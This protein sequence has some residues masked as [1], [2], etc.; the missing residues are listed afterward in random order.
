MS[1]PE[2]SELFERLATTPSDQMA[3]AAK[4]ADHLTPEDE[5][6]YQR[7]N[8]A[9][10]RRTMRLIRSYSAWTVYGL[11]VLIALAILGLFFVLLWRYGVD[12]WSRPDKASGVVTG[13][14]QFLFGVFVT[15]G[16]ELLIKKASGKDP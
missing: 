6:A 8:R 13:L 16:A 5:E 7:G 9:A 2:D 12:L 10:M 15:L 14:L 1:P 3:R 11:G 4:R